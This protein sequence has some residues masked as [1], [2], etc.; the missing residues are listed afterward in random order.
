RGVTAT[1]RATRSGLAVAVWERRGAAAR[2]RRLLLEGETEGRYAG[3]NEA[4]TGFRLTM[5]LAVGCSPPGWAWS[6]A[7][8]FEALIYR[9]MPGG[10][11]AGWLRE[12][13]GSSYA[14]VKLT[15]MLEKARDLVADSPRIRCRD[16]ALEA[17]GAV[18]RR[19][20]SVCWRTRGGWG[21]RLQEPR[22]ASG[23]VRTRGR[24]APH[25]LGAA[26]D[27]T[28]G[29]CEGDRRSQQRAAAERRIAGGT[30]I[31]VGQ[32]TLHAVAAEG[33]RQPR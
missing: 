29:L 19:V 3:H 1:V 16:V 33:P 27:G 4:D 7:D 24:A 28:D 9:P 10:M 5:A 32:G 18:R 15:A 25:R 2:M 20:K 31:W 26:A 6:P 14:E 13:K 12:R 8:F 21:H 11:W 22:C 17:V 30:G 23:D